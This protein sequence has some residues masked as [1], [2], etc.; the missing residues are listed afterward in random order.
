[1]CQNN[2]DNMQ[3]SD[4]SRK[5][6]P[7][8][9]NSSTRE[10]DQPVGPRKNRNHREPGPYWHK[11]P[12]C[13]KIPYDTDMPFEQRLLPKKAKQKERKGSRHIRIQLLIVI[14]FFSWAGSCI[15]QANAAKGKSVQE[16]IAQEIIRFHV[17][18]NSDSTED[19]ALKYK[20]KDALV[21]E[22]TPRLKTVTD[23]TEGRR[24]I[25]SGLASIQTV[26][27][28]TISDNGYYYPV[29]VTLEPVYFPMKVY[30]D[31]TFP[32]GTYEA[33]RVQ[34]GE[35]AGKNW[36]CVMFPP[37]CF[38]DETYSIVDSD[39]DKQLKGLLTEEEYDALKGQKVSVKYKFKLWESFK[40]LFT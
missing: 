34:I 1:M 31:Y 38:V 2:S 6:L 20:V 33:L 16:G 35:A 32:P 10:T 36:W 24:I 5:S 7:Y 30:G 4:F 3:D 21:K 14:L 23:I 18:A 12:E 40:K 15:I 39:T 11:P 27:E 8:Q 37:L 29:K 26:A 22:L 17:I 28:K 13:R 25:R 19:Q 9:T